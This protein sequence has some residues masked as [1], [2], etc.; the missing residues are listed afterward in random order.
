MVRRDQGSH[1]LLSGGLGS[2]NQP[3]SGR[4]PEWMAQSAVVRD[5]RVLE[6]RRRRA[7]RPVLTVA[8]SGPYDLSTRLR[9]PASSRQAGGVL[10]G[11]PRRPGAG[12]EDLNVSAGQFP[13]ASQGL[14]LRPP[15]PGYGTTWVPALPA[16]ARPTW[17]GSVMIASSV[18][19]AR[20]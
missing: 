2:R 1:H 18:P 14:C 12:R 4:I 9:D 19:A 7:N 17:A 15:C 5:Y 20:A 13:G 6:T 10:P 16:R 11:L 8:E 3:F